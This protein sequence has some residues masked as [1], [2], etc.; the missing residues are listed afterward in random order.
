MD[1]LL[2][3][4][5]NV[6]GVF[7]ERVRHSAYHDERRPDWLRHILA[8][9]YY[10]LP[11]VALASLFVSWK[12]TAVSASLFVISLIAWVATEEDDPKFG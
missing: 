9:S 3:I 8:A 2:E 10:V 1:W 6:I 12:L 4:L 5:H 7:S 11:V